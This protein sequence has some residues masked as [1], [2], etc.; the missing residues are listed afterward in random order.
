MNQQENKYHKNIKEISII[1]KNI[2]IFIILL[3][4]S[5]NLTAIVPAPSWTGKNK[6]ITKI[7]KN[8]V[9]ISKYIKNIKKYHNL[10][11]HTSAES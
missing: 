1:S 11:H 5:D 10:H 7:S 2:R 9:K 6:N 3:V 4:H 8:N